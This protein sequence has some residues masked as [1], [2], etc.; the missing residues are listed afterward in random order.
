LAVNRPRLIASDFLAV[1][2]DMMDEHSLNSRRLRW[3]RILPAAVL[4]AF[5]IRFALVNAGLASLW[6]VAPVLA[7]PAGL[8][9]LIKYRDEPTGICALVIILSG[10]SAGLLWY[11][12]HPDW[13]PTLQLWFA[14][15]CAAIAVLGFGGTFVRGYVSAPF[16]PVGA[17]LFLVLAIGVQTAVMVHGYNSHDTWYTIRDSYIISK[18]QFRILQTVLIVVICFF[19]ILFGY[20]FGHFSSKLS[21]GRLSVWHRI[22]LFYLRLPLHHPSVS[23]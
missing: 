3:R 7:A 17:P 10:S 23:N 14:S 19:F 16:R 6:I 8:I 20:L 13:K 5:S 11:L 2:E 12:D 4:C 18:D 1:E 21:C 22:N 9:L 15:T